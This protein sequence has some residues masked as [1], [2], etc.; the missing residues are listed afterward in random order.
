MSKS[1]LQPVMFDYTKFLGVSSSGRR[2]QFVDLFHSLAP[3]I[4]SVRKLNQ[5]AV[6]SSE[7]RLWNSALKQLSSTHSDEKNLIKLIKLAKLE[8]IRQ[9]EIFLP[10]AFELNEIEH[11]SHLGKV[12]IKTID[13]EH[14]HVEL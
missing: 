3:F 6:L 10:Y 7:Q 5:S 8:G 11:I 9:L 14:W 12:V 4:F 1:P 2:W 13:E